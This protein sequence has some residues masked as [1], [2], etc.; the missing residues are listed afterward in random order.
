LR[1]KET[2]GSYISR[3]NIRRLPKPKFINW[4]VHEEDVTI[5]GAKVECYRIEGDIDEAQL[6]SWALHVRRHY[7]RDDDLDAYT[8]YYEVPASDYLAQKIPDI[9]QIMTGDFS[10]III[11]DLLQFIEGYQVPRY[12]QYGREDKN[13]SG[14]GTDILAY[15]IGN[16]EQP[17]P[18]DVL[19][20]VEV[21]SRSGSAKVKDG[22]KEA[23]SDSL[24]D[25]SRTA[26]TI[27]YFSERS[28]QGNDLVTASELKRF[29]LASEHPYR[30]EYSIGVTAGTDDISRAISRST[31]E[32]LGIVSG[33]TVFIVHRKHMM[34]LIK[35]IYSRCRS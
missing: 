13:S 6:D 14:H 16:P 2:E 35:R 28:L 31:A 34:D 12:K 25:R 30:E 23:A 27:A 21:K 10:E 32:D 8:H 5:E 18:D 24:K 22:I 7:C 9:T 29:L 20:A 33:E 26:M 19:L 3:A 11:S 1:M 17:S 4:L 15:K